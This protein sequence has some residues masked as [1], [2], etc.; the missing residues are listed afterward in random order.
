MSR[1]LRVLDGVLVNDLSTLTRVRNALRALARVPARMARDGADAINE[2]L[3]AQATAGT[4]PYG[5]PHAPLKRPR[6][7]GRAGPPL[8]DSGDSY[9]LTKAKP[10]SGAGI[11]IT[12]GG[13][14]KWHMD[15]TANRPR[16]AALP[17]SG[18]PATWKR[19]LEAV[20]QRLVGAM[21]KGGK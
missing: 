11:G 3:R 5:R 4:D 7:S 21:L 13:H 12:L 8:V 18:M 2:R 19:A 6:V 14:L 9:A 16:R 20:E 10:L 15:P 17:L 1:G